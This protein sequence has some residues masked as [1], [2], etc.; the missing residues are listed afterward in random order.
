MYFESLGA[1][2]AM[3]GH[4]AYVWS[5]YF[6]A[7]VVVGMILILPQRRSRKLLRGLAGEVR[8]SQAQAAAVTDS[9]TGKR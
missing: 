7:I 1:A 3:E 2:M 9:S 8:R 4:G 5:A 6:I